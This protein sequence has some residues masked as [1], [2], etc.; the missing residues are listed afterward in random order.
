M[1]HTE[2]QPERNRQFATFFMKDLFFGIDVRKVQEVLRAQEMT[3]VPLAPNV[4][5]GLINLRGQI[6]AAIDMRERLELP[7]RDSGQEPMNMIVR[8]DDGAVSLLVD[9]IGDVI[10]VAAE[11]YEPVPE[12]MTGTLRQ[13]VEGVYKLDGRLLLVLDTD[14]TLQL[15]P[16]L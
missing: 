2:N 11:S 1:S 14:R 5:R 8:A 3:R 7:A 13:L 16:A 6:V 10:H 15:Q 12:T 9:E 4:L